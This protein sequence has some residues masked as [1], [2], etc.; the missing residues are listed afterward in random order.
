MKILYKNILIRDAKENDK[1]YV[2]RQGVERHVYF[3]MD[4]DFY[5]VH[6]R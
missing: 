6:G 5:G 1:G 3:F 4:D 2:R